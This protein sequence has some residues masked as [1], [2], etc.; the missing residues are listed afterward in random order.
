M[1]CDKYPKVKD[2]AEHCESY[3]KRSRKVDRARYQAQKRRKLGEIGN[4]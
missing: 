1:S 2:R 3:K 4:V